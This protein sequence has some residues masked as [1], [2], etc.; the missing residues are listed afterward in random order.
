V[1]AQDVIVGRFGRV[2]S[3]ASGVS[4]AQGGGAP[5]AFLKAVFVGVIALESATA[6][7]FVMIGTYLHRGIGTWI[8]V[9]MF[10]SP[11]EILLMLG[12]VVS[13]AS[14]GPAVAARRTRALGWPMTLFGLALV[15]G[16]ARGAVAGGDMY[17]GL[18]EIRYLLY[19]PACFV[20]ARAAIRRVE[21]V[22]SL[23]GAGLIAAALFAVEG[24]YR[25]FALVNTGTLG[26]VED[27][28]YEHEDVIFLATFLIAIAASL[29]FPASARVRTTG[30]LL[31]PI[32]LFTLLASNRRAG[33]IVLLIGLLIVALAAFAVR[34]KAFFVSAVP[35]A[36]AA[37][38]YVALFWNA[39]G[40]LGQPARAVRSLY[41]PDARDASSN[42]YRLL[43]GYDI[44]ATIK[45]DPI[46]GVGFGREFLMPATLPDLSW[47]PFW[48][49]EPHNNVLW[50]WLKLGVVGYLVFWFLMGTAISRAAAGVRRLQDPQ[51]RLA[52]LFCL[53]SV[54]A[55][56]VF[57]YVDLGLVSGRVTAF[58]GTVLGIISVL[59]AIDRP[60]VATR[61][62]GT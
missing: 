50:M 37:V 47:W 21:D 25:K 55:V 62:V 10:V 54:V 1:F 27:F 56:L 24:A 35:G 41:E 5:R 57:A 60:M 15:V 29:L 58:L 20:I 18:W 44:Y 59:K 16:F 6:D 53:V 61:E 52:A 34:R 39:S 12:V 8:G 13:L 43:E 26:L 32:L 3:A 38:L 14:S 7:P 19:I 11:L 9:P 22:T 46:L 28:A 23:L 30:L 4:V 45:D 33:I 40:L 17:V 31:A 42:L 48:R 2:A 36:I 49:F 51:L